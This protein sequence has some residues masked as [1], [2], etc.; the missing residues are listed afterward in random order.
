MAPKALLSLASLSPPDAVS[1]H[2]KSE[3]FVIAGIA[4]ARSWFPRAG[5]F[6]LREW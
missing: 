4:E 2:L 3:R 1:Q 5:F 6:V